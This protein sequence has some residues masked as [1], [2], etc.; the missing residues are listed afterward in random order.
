MTGSN[1]PFTEIPFAEIIADL[2]SLAASKTTGAI[3]LATDEDRAA[4]FVM[5]RGKIVHF[6]YAGKEGLSALVE[7]AGI[8]AG[9]YA[10]QPGLAG[11]PRMAL[12]SNEVLLTA[13]ESVEAA[14]AL[15]RSLEEAAARKAAIPPPAPLTPREKWVLETSLAHLIGP[16]AILICADHFRS[17]AGLEA[18]IDALAA[19]L[20]SGQQSDQFRALVRDEL[21]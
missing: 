1:I 19:E 15:V 8:K 13:L 10:F 18:T 17:P 9:R 16:I 2:K 6:E 11:L 5:D 21:G 7:M 14:T 4:R 12:P 3:L 20:P